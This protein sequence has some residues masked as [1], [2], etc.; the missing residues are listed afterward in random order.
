MLIKKFFKT[1]FH[2]RFTFN[3][4]IRLLAGS[5]GK[6]KYT[7]TEKREIPIIVSLTS[8]EDRF[9]DLEISLYSL[10]IQSLKPDK[11]ILWLSDE[12][13]SINDIPY[14]I[15]RYIKNGLEIRFVKDIGSYTKAIYTFQEFRDCIIVT[16][17]DDVYYPK[18]WL[19]KLYHSYIAPPQ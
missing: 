15:T 13:K 2:L 1:R 12:I 8:Y 14:E 17:D 16:A 10:L 6:E 18:D 3:P 5:L 19:Q 7:N 11:I 4:L 9:K